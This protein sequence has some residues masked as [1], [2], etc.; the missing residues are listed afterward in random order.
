MD[1]E[2]EVAVVERPKDTAGAGRGTWRSPNCGL[3]AGAEVPDRDGTRGLRT[4][5]HSRPFLFIAGTGSQE[6]AEL[7]G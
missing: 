6:V 7:P 1:E 5:P 4:E 3:C 2:T